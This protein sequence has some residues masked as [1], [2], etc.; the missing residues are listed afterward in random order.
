MRRP[1]QAMLFAALVAATA[2]E[3]DAQNHC[4]RHAGARGCRLAGSGRRWPG[5][6]EPERAQSRSRREV[7]AQDTAPDLFPEDN[8]ED[9]NA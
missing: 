5:E 1:T 7:N 8:R 3:Q 4:W 9:G 6:R 2:G